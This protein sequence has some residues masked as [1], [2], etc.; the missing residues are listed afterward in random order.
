MFFLHKRKK[1]L[2]AIAAFLLLNSL[3]QI[4]APSAA[5][6]LTAGPSQPEVQSFSPVETSEMVDM[7]SGDFSYNIPLLDV[8]GYPINLAYN[9]GITPDQEASWVGM[10]WNINPGVVNRSVRG[11]PD[12][13][14]GDE[15]QREFNMKPNKTYGG[16]LGMKV[17]LFSLTKAKKVKPSLTMSLG[18]R[19][20]NYTG[21][22]S[23]LSISPALSIGGSSKSYLNIGL[24]LSASSQDGTN[25]SP[26]V[27]FGYQIKNE[28]AKHG[29]SGLGI[30]IGVN[31]NSRQ[32]LNSLTVGPE[33]KTTRDREKANKS[34]N[35]FNKAGDGSSFATTISF[36]YPTFTP[37]SEMS[38]ESDAYS[39]QATI[40]SEVKYTHP[41][42]VI[43]GYYSKNKLTSTVVKNPAYGYLY[44]QDGNAHTSLHDFNRE[45]DGAVQLS[46]PNVGLANFTFDIYGVSGQGIGGVYRPYRTDIG[47][48]FD[49]KVQN[50]SSKSYSLGL[51]IGVGGYVK[52]GANLN[53]IL[54]SSISGGWFGDNY[55]YS[56]AS[57]RGK[58][59]MKAAGEKTV[60]ANMDFFNSIGGFAAVR[61]HI[62]AAKEMARVYSSLEEN[63][64][65]NL[66]TISSSTNRSNR[67]PVTQSLLMLTQKE[68]A[69]YGMMK[70]IENHLV[71]KFD[72][73]GSNMRY[74]SLKAVTKINREADYP[75]HHIGEIVSVRPDGSRY[76]YSIPAYNKHQKE[77]TFSIGDS[78]APN[79]NTGLVEYNPNGDNSTG[80]IKGQENY[81]ES[82]TT[83]K[84]A[85]SYLLTAIVS[86]DY[87]DR[88][89]DGPTDDDN[90]TYTKINYSKAVD[91]FQWRT[92]VQENMAS[93]NEGL[94]SNDYR[95]QKVS[96][97]KAS[98]IYGQK[99]LWYVHSIETR[100][101]IA[102]FVLENR[103][104][105]Q[106]VKGENGGINVDTINSPKRLVK[107][108]LYAKTKQYASNTASAIA[109]L[110]IKEVNFVYDYS[111]C[112]K[113]PNNNGLGTNGAKSVINYQG[114]TLPGA[115]NGKLTLKEVYFTYG[116]SGKG[117]YSSYKFKYAGTGN[118]ED[119]DKNLIAL[120]TYNMKDYDRWGNYKPNTGGPYDN[121]LVLTAA[122]FPYAEQ[123]KTKADRYAT[124]WNLNYISLPSGGTINVEYE[125]DDYAY[126]Q[127]RNA[128]QMFKVSGVANRDDLESDGLPE[129]KI[130]PDRLINTDNV[131]N[132]LIVFEFAKPITASTTNEVKAI[133]KRDYLKE[134]NQLYFRFFVRIG[135]ENYSYEFIPGYI[136]NVDYGVVK[137]TGNTY[138]YGWIEVAGVGIRMKGGG[139]DTNPISRAAWQFAQLYVPRI[140]YS[141]NK[142]IDTEMSG[143]GQVLESIVDALGSIKE[144]VKGINKIMRDGNKGVIFRK[145]KSWIRLYNP[146]GKKIGGGHRVKKVQLSDHWSQMSNQTVDDGL[147]GQTYEYTQVIQRT[148]GSKDTISSGV[149]SYEPLI[150]GDENPFREPVK[151][152]NPDKDKF[153]VPSRDYYLEKPFGES[154]FPSPSIVYS[155]VKV[156]SIKSGTGYIV[157]EHYTAKDYPVRVSQTNL[158]GNSR[159][160]EKPS[161][162]A[163]L[164]KLKNYDY[165]TI[166]QGYCIILN[167]MHGK[168]KG[169]TV[170]GQTGDRPISSVSYAYRTSKVQLSPPLRSSTETITV[171]R[172]NNEVPVVYKNSTG[173]GRIQN[174]MIGVDYDVAYDS[175]ESVSAVRNSKLDI[176]SD[177]SSLLDPYIIPFP[178]PIPGLQR[179]KTRFR[180]AVVTKVIN[181]YGILESTTATEDGASVKTT[182]LLYDAETGDVL[183]TGTTNQFGDP[184]YSFTYPAHW[185]YDGMGPAYKNIAFETSNLSNDSYMFKVGDELGV[186]L[187]NGQYK[188]GWVLGI[189]SG[190]VQVIDEKGV[191]IHNIASVKIIRSGRRNMQSIP[192]GTVTTLKNPIISNNLGF[193][194]V[195]NA[196][197]V[198]FYDSWKGACDMGFDPDNNFNPFIEGT[199]GNWRVKRSYV[200]LTQRTQSADNDNTNIRQD[201]VFKD[202]TAFW[203]PPTGAGTGDWGKDTLKWQYTSEV[204]KYSPFGYELEN[205]DP[206][207]RYSAALYGYQGGV[208]PIGVANNAKYGEIA[209][210]NFEDYFSYISGLRSKHL[211]IKS[212]YGFDNAGFIGKDIFHSGKNSLGVKPGKTFVYENVIISCE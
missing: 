157:H 72:R 148:D 19:Y 25:I 57:F 179:E 27:S 131:P 24:G 145:E 172:L 115:L 37:Y 85:H 30:N 56:E 63:H 170:Y 88:T 21:Y 68:A 133:M 80:N 73:A 96:D 41:S 169:Q 158:D 185:A 14:D 203:T 112:L 160:R 17:E 192:V 120:N 65:A 152:N 208:L 199:R 51:E 100:T 45:K 164:A 165:L 64:G 126:V 122:E 209:F 205:R 127:D 183:L 191:D 40:G 193:E 210:E 28:S 144:A 6:A 117:K 12:D 31:V 101:H 207:N 166:S 38:F 62:F 58:A 153:L 206:L 98:Y 212:G 136:E 200:Y 202:F 84:Y 66:K 79:Y 118:A 97:D 143:I 75:G 42:G 22:A 4:I 69:N 167:D 60:E 132:N 196:G 92:P 67:Q 111:T 174:A 129:N 49:P 110:P 8:G 86:A 140:A 198:E 176:N 113:V 146:D 109:A 35:P 188:R 46:T 141:G 26:N 7:T 175:R 104:D 163:K 95:E 168:P 171:E 154:F 55:L 211:K 151:Y 54:S 107:I 47:M 184:V 102:Q 177:I 9:A 13:F 147:Y 125:A 105:A 36:G 137:G 59:F 89:G 10:G 106:G 32:G 204:T 1:T 197:A 2:R 83:P 99:E 161:G 33:L 103:D 11:L 121:P 23:D 142:A 130:N 90:G 18:V 156:S 114:S 123:D 108:S 16:S 187:S 124:L 87:S 186:L 173:G 159:I 78:K 150:G 52:L 135:T 119:D 29:S 180:S 82:V 190:N 43:S 116:A 44:S 182:N 201:G 149:A 128:M 71:N 162:I 139:N 50:G 195:L 138:K 181:Q 48:L 20:N 74:D 76:I 189:V 178:I 155:R 3:V 70:Q 61:P 39:F 53:K 94:K 5:Y 34:K 81:F 15:V 194:Q 77:V 91:N 93:H 134:M